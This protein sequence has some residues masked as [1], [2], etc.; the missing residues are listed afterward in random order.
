MPQRIV[1]LVGSM[2][3]HAE[4]RSAQVLHDGRDA[5]RVAPEVSVNVLHARSSNRG[6]EIGGFEQVRKA[7]GQAGTRGAHI[8]C[9][10]QKFRQDCNRVRC[11]CAAEG[12][13]P[14]HR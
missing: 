8:L 11:K 3:R 12:S 13:R 4:A 1:E 7:L 10:R 6:E 2:H 14:P 5:R 9:D